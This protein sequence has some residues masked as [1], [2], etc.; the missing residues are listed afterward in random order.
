VRGLTRGRA[1]LLLSIAELLGMSVW[2]SASALAPELR[3]QWGLSAVESGWLTTAVQLGFVA[4]TAVAA[5][6][7]VAD[8]LPARA[9][10]G[11]SALAAGASNT[12]LLLTGGFLAALVTRFLTGFFL[13]GVY[14]PRASYIDDKES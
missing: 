3:S 5:L 8:L 14:P 11:V 2:F 7:N 1:L 13:A 4:G 6:L 9:L 12:A 10:F